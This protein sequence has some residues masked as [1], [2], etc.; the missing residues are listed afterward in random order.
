MADETEEHAQARL[1][2][3]EEEIEKVKK[4][5]LASLRE[6]W[7][8]E[9]LGMGDV[10]DIR[11][12]L[13]DV[14]LE[15]TH[16]SAL[17]KEKQSTN[18]PVGEGEYQKLYELDMQKKQLS[19]KLEAANTAEPEKGDAAAAASGSRTRKKSPRSSAPG[20]AFPCRG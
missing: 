16:L 15:F 14:E 8:A 17:I 13:N 12:R 9:K 18:Q 3:I 6:Q 19:E 10:A 7:E 11:S 5:K 1:S 20:P 4:H 2:D